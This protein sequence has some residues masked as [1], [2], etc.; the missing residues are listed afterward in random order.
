MLAT[1]NNCDRKKKNSGVERNLREPKDL[2][3]TCNTTKRAPGTALFCFQNRNNI[4]EM[5]SS[6][7]AVRVGVLTRHDKQAPMPI[8][9]V[10]FTTIQKQFGS[11][12]VETATTRVATGTRYATLQ[13]NLGYDLFLAIGKSAYSVNRI[14]I[15]CVGTFRDLSNLICSLG[16]VLCEPVHAARCCSTCP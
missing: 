16:C 10:W 6:L 1:Y 14:D 13:H 4:T 2:G 3:C 7:P 12:C 8:R 5:Q 9:Q 11:A 15:A